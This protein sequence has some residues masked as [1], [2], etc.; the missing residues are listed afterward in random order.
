MCRVITILNTPY[1]SLG[2]LPK[3]HW[4]DTLCLNHSSPKSSPP[5]PPPPSTAFNITKFG[6]KTLTVFL[7]FTRGSSPSAPLISLPRSST[8]TTLTLQLKLFQSLKTSL[9]RTSSTVRRMT[10]C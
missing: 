6:S 4:L 10:S 1:P 8:T 3:L 2:D 5:P 9:T 7:N